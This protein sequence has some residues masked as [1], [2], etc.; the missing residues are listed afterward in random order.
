MKKRNQ[1]I[2]KTVG[3]TAITLALS[4]G[5][6]NAD[7]PDKFIAGDSATIACGTVS[8]WARVNGAGKVVWVGLTIPLSMAE[9]MPAPG[10][11]PASAI[12]ALNFPAVVQQTTY[13]N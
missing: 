7:Q 11:G 2:M 12:A 9:N 10:S 13:F 3:L 5:A 4:A 8:T 1:I 6:A